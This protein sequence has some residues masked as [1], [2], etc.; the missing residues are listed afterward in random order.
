MTFEGDELE[1]LRQSTSKM[2]LAV[3][4]L[5]VPIAFIIALTLGADWL[6]PVSFLVAMALAAT[7]SWRM[8]GNGP[9][10]RLVFAVALM[11][12]VSMFVF[13]FA[14]HLW[15]VDMHMYFFAALAILVA[16]CDYRPIVA[17]T[18]AVALHHLT[19]NLI[20]PAAVYPG[21][22]DLGHSPCHN[23]ANR[24][25]RLNLAGADTFESL[26]DGGRENGGGQ[27]CKRG[28]SAC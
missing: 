16:Y 19:L 15:Q 9:S 26:R 23:P 12:G 14:G 2:L 27:G 22:A 4:W 3:L 5:H 13:Q 25:R 1:C 7:L 28:R 17:G 24:G 21:G 6:V 18:A 11:A 20:L 8:S 10:T